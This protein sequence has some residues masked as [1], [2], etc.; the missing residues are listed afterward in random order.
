MTRFFA[1][2]AVFTLAACSTAAAGPP[3]PTET[4]RASAEVLGEFRAL[5]LK[6]IP[7]A[8]LADAK[9]VAVFP[10][11]LKAGFVIGGRHGR[12]VVL[13]READ[14]RWGEPTFLRLTGAG[15]GVQA[16]IEAS[17]VVLVFKSRGG[18]ERVLAG[19]GKLALGG[20]ATIAAGPVGRDAAAATD[21]RLRAEIY[22][23]SRARGLFA[24]V[25]LEG[26]VIGNDVDA[27]KA[28]KNRLR[29]EEARAIEELKVKLVE[30]A[31]PP[32]ERPRR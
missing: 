18:L 22:S 5:P 7:P 31:A 19:K 9:A 10:D 2:T 20:E 25:S 28:F 3:S 15:I 1:Y 8:L 24:G 29:P 26:S 32:V 14:G 27:N 30:A 13:C 17:D 11:V 6:C 16:G 12:G 4:L 23:Y 21:A